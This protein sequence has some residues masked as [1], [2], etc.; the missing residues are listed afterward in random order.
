ML[1]VNGERDQRD[2]KDQKDLNYQ[3]DIRD[4]MGQE[5]KE[6]LTLGFLR[7][8]YEWFEVVGKLREMRLTRL[9]PG[10]FFNYMLMS[11]RDKDFYVLGRGKKKRAGRPR[12]Q[13]GRIDGIYK[14][15]RKRPGDEKRRAG[16]PRSQGGR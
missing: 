6:T 7:N 4:E 8:P 11:M 1:I 15:G 3:K 9:E 5:K 2:I 13:G 12:S 14:R 16:R 10:K